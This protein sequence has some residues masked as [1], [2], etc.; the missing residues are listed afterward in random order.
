MGGELRK[1]GIV[2]CVVL[3]MN[4]VKTEIEKSMLGFREAQ[5]IIAAHAHS[6]G[7]EM[8]ALDRALERVLAEPVSADRD[9]PPFNR[10]A[11]DGFAIKLDDF[12]KGIREFQIV[13]TVFAGQVAAK[14][15]SSGQCFKIM[16]G[17]PLPVSS[18]IVVRRED[19]TEKEGFVRIL[20]VELRPFQNIARKGEDVS[21]GEEVL[22]SSI[23][24]QPAVITALAS[25][26][27]AEVLV[28]KLPKIALFTTGDEVV[29]VH[30]PVLPQQIR[31]S[32]AHLLQS[33]LK[34]W[35][36]EPFQIAHIPD[37]EEALLNTLAD[38]MTYDV[39]VMS[40]GV[41]AGDADY[42]PKVLD[43]LGVKK[44]FHKVAIKPG[45]PVWCGIMPNGGIVF[46]LPG[47]P[48]SCHVTFKLFIE[49]YLIHSFGLEGARELRVPFSGQ[50]RKKTTL[51]E[52]FPVKLQYSPVVAIPLS[53]NGSGDVLAALH[54]DAFALQPAEQMELSEGD[55]V[56]CYLI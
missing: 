41:S 6:F 32:N 7:R 54:A 37:R 29:P 26:G 33:L 42:V 18:D 21:A 55:F 25:L 43:V 1:Y 49:T 19:T 38:V 12:E 13:E 23:R 8:V 15:I 40:G 44:L 48:L 9:Y 36:I 28:E 50:R 31:N 20:D 47:N 53:F 3:W 52:F 2:V 17:A 46:A 45:K 14:S 39:V 24:I 16:T 22:H 27:K 51:D 35:N 5:Q 10:V 56:I 11:M 4:Y 30:Q 34:Q